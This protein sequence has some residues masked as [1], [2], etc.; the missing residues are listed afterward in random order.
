MG[1]GLGSFYLLG[2]LLFHGPAVYTPLF[3]TSYAT[4]ACVDV[5]LLVTALRV[6]GP[7]AHS[8]DLI[9]CVF[10]I[11]QCRHPYLLFFFFFL[12]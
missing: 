3:S 2:R 12:V 7:F 9:S 8:L 10:N 1:Q 4:W 11:H 5:T 6:S